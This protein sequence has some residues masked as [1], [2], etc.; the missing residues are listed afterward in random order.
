MI[1]IVLIETD[2]SLYWL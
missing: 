1:Y 2:S